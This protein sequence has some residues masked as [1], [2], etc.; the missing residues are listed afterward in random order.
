MFALEWHAQA[1]S[2]LSGTRLAASLAAGTRRAASDAFGHGWRCSVLLDHSDSRRS[3]SWRPVT[4]DGLIV[5]FAG[6][7]ANAREL[8]ADLGL[9]WPATPSTDDLARLYGRL[10]RQ[11]PARCDLRAIGEYAAASFDLAQQTLRLV[12]SPLRAPPLHYQQRGHRVIASTV[13][14]P[15]LAA[16]TT[17]QLDALKLADNA[18]F[19][20]NTDRTGWYEGLAKVPLG[21]TVEFGTGAARTRRYY[22]PLALPQV[23]LPR[24]EDYVE[25]AGVLLK[26]AVAAS[27]DG[28]SRPGVLLSGGLDS[29]LVAGAAL[30]ILPPAQD[31]PAFTFVPQA[32]WD[33]RVPP[34]TYGDERPYVDA[35]AALH[36]RVRPHYL[37]NHGLAFNHRMPE[38]FHLTGIAPINLSNYSPYHEPWRAAQ[39]AGCDVLLLPQWGN[40]TFSNAGEWGLIEYFLRGRWG[41]LTAGLRALADD[42][43]P[44]WRRV[45]GECLLPLLPPAL[46]R[47]QRA[48]RGVRDTRE[49]ASPLRADYVAAHGLNARGDAQGGALG[50][51]TPRNQ[52]QWLTRALNGAFEESA[53]V[54]LGFEQLYGV[55]MRDPAAYRPLAEFCFGLPTDLYLR[56]G[57]NRWL[58][59]Q[60]ARGVLPEAQ[61]T[62]LRSGRHHPDW[63]AKLA[64]QREA[65][66]AEL[67]RLEQVPELA[68]MLDF[69][70]LKAALDDWPEQTPIGA[71]AL[72]LQVALTRGLTTARFINSVAG[73]NC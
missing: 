38:L 42:D 24:A 62:N 17:P 12:R 69:P 11:S 44:M 1:Q 47:W 9:V 61:R 34:G 37:D 71:D 54:W 14:R 65:L 51:A 31:L 27:L 45:I 60:L 4:T 40:E 18:W 43:R 66:R 30:E 23:R 46:W 67:D 50:A 49:L 68:E 26:Q 6:H 48:V 57:E 10:L 28:F 16:G 21:S 3:K 8:A 55:A 73:R 36:P 7:L 64:P 13:P 52:R 39:Q 19:N 29:S 33:G 63:L 35:F 32:D 15:I 2:E 70:R 72:P 58:A 53:D 20:Y 59:R 5:L 41:E 56:G 25:Q 22:D